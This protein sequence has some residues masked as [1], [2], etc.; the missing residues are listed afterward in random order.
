[1]ADDLDPYIL[2]LMAKIVSAHL[3]RSHVEAGA[4]PDL[5]RS[6][7]RTL[8][9]AG[10]P[11]PVPLPVAPAV[12]VR[13][14]VFP[15][16]IVCLEDGKKLKMLKRHL[17]V[18]YGMTPEQYRHRWGLPASYPMVAPSYAGHR[19]AL[20]KELGLGRRPADARGTSL[21]QPAGPA[22]VAEPRVTRVRARRARGS[23]G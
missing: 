10:A 1:M 4:L 2:R 13:K 8:A 23:K 19:A 22:P 5:I 6:V 7:Y 18:S 16:H 11:K 15:D 21:D 14:S 20:A 9:L 12:P 17:Q 3:K